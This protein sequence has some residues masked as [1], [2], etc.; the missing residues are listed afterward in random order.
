MRVSL[1]WLK[2][3][4]NFD[5]S[6]DKISQQ[7]SLVG[8]EVEAVEIL[9]ELHKDIVVGFVLQIY[10]HP[11]TDKLKICW[12]DI[13]ESN[14]IQIVCGASN[15]KEGIHVPI[16]KNGVVIPA[17]G[18]T[19]KSSEF[20]G[21]LSS[22]MI[23]SFEE[24]GKQKSSTNGI[25][26]LEDILDQVP[27]LGT[28][29]S[30]ILGSNDTILELAI[31]ANRP[32]SLSIIGIARE[33]AALTGG[34]L[35]FPAKSPINEVR[36]LPISV[37]E[38]TNHIM[39]HGGIYSIT[40]ISNL[41]VMPS[42]L[43][44]QRRLESSGIQPIN[45]I[46]DIINYV[47]IEQ[48]QP[49]RAFDTNALDKLSTSPLNPSLLSLRQGNNGESINFINCD[50]LIKVSSESLLVTYDDHPIELAGVTGTSFSDV[51]NLTTS[52]WLEAAVFSPQDVRISARQAG[53]RTESSSRFEK[54]VPKELTLIS[55]KRAITLLQELANGKI[56][57]TWTNQYETNIVKPINLCRNNLH[58]LLGPIQVDT[59]GAT[60]PLADECIER[61]LISLGCSLNMTDNGWEVIVPSNRQLDLQREV[62]LI[63]EIA[64]LVGLDNFTTHLP[65]PILPGVLSNYQ[66]VERKLKSLLIYSGLQE[67]VT[68]SLVP[69]VTTDE[70]ID[71]PKRVAIAN[72]LLTETSHLRESLWPEHIKAARRNLQASQ[73]GYWAFEIG[74]VFRFVSKEKPPEQLLILSGI[75]CGERNRSCWAIS[76]KEI[77]P[78]YYYARGI[79]EEIFASMALL[80]SDY[81]LKR[82]SLLHPGRATEIIVEGYPTGWFGQF[83]PE[84]AIHNNLPESTY[85]F[86]FK[87][88]KLLLAGTQE[89]KLNPLFRPFATA[90]ASDRDLSM[91][92][93]F[94][95]SSSDLLNSILKAGNPLLESAKLIDCFDGQQLGEGK[96][97]LTFRLRYRSM[98]ETLT[99]KDVNI[100]HNR[101]INNLKEQ[102][103]IVLRV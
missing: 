32:D 16:A 23:C 73:T 79:L 75:I 10:P 54:G 76:D 103:Q 81:P 89:T 7:L 78:N 98:K 56:G 94:G 72:P 93:P 50:H 15:I 29:V 36:F 21:V 65:D 14:P 85:L 44:M 26:A 58:K 1:Q 71:L 66:T 100:V 3:L 87:L 59:K 74:H 97:S 42:P 30:L 9:K 95:L 101:L 102:F 55:L 25:V 18:I 13:G 22:G 12:L 68:L 41:R 28:A 45:N 88:E 8:F 40:E 24:L 77:E 37:S 62:D 27:N 39:K 69:P 49:M 63:E 99:D 70:R 33:I 57:N 38:E 17:K 61:I 64:R 52:I 31:T 90:P 19:I 34:E 86:E 91:I 46:V 80:A 67:V 96:C 35:R 6:V 51:S 82:N 20:R 84:L 5:W 60:E 83:H 53:L 48:G 2:E 43:W 92:V 47:M 11:N 4:V